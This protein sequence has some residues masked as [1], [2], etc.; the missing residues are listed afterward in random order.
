M[1][2]PDLEIRITI[3]HVVADVGGAIRGTET[4]DCGRDRGLTSVICA[5]REASI[6]VRKEDHVAC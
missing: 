2:L 3:C 4:L 6:T 1:Q 5:H